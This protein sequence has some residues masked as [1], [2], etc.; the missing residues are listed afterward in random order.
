MFAEKTVH[1]GVLLVRHGII[2]LIDRTH[3]QYSCVYL[4]SQNPSIQ[5]SCISLNIQK[6]LFSYIYQKFSRLVYAAAAEWAVG[7]CIYCMYGC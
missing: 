4:N 2:P 7:H 5:Y 1:N 6:F 3:I